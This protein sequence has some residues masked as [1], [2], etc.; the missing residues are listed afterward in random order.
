MNATA[1]NPSPEAAVPD[2]MP[3]ASVVQTAKVAVQTMNGL[4]A[5][6]PRHPR[7]KTLQQRAGD[8]RVVPGRAR[9]VAPKALETPA[10]VTA[11]ALES[12]H[13]KLL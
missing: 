13:Q 12:G 8:D 3:V 6:A 9:A 2:G 10:T 7:I 11:R 1:R 5:A 4:A